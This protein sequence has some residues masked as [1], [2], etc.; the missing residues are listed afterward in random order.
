MGDLEEIQMALPVSV[1][2]P[3]AVGIPS[4]YVAQQNIRLQLYRRLADLRREDELKTLAEEFEDRFGPLPQ[5][6]LDLFYQMRIKLLAERAGLVSLTVEGDQIVM[7]YPA[8]PAGIQTMALP[9]IG[10]GARPGKNA[11]WM[12]MG[13]E[14]RDT[15]PEALS[16]IINVKGKGR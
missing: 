8:V 14:W 1:D 12:A 4:A 6:V 2:L 9:E 3:L 13:N 11:Y 10:Q 15:L 5:Q 7:R 16:A